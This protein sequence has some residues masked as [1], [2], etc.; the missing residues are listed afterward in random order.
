MARA[1]LESLAVR[2]GQRVAAG[3]V[4]ARLDPTLPEADRAALRAEARALAAE[5]A[6]IEAELAGR[7]L[8]VRNG[9]TA[10]QAEVLERRSAATAVR[11][12]ALD[13]AREGL[14]RERDLAAALVP[15]L[16]EQLALA[17]EVEARRA[18]LAARRAAPESTAIEARAARIGAETALG[19]NA[20]RLAEIDRHLRALRDEAHALTA[21]TRRALAETLPPLRLRAAQVDDALGKA[22]RLAD[23]SALRAPR[24][25]TVIAIAPG[26]PGAVMAEGE[27]LISL[28]PADA[29]LLV[30]V[31]VPSRDVGRLS[32]GDAVALKVDAFPWRRFGAGEGRIES[33]GPLSIAPEGG[34]AP[35][36]PVRV[37]LVAPPPQAALLP[38][39]T[40]SVE[41]RTG[42][43]TV[44]DFFLDPL[45]RGLSESLREP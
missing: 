3:E 33:I 45:M 18:D 27:A 6:R 38:G 41:V 7:P 25:G 43:R 39:M 16:E 31:M 42:T 21:E 2:P 40:L 37:A 35:L 12:A 26:G 30:E 36:H 19:A 14:A 5:I 32:P 34:G 24:A 10:L 29:P 1:V 4:L 44:L 22:G 17:R 15:Q 8:A 9:E 11:L 23:L 13:A 20:L 28:I